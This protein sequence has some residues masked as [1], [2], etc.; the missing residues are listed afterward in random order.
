[1]AF[2]LRALIFDLDGVIAS[3]LPLHYDSWQRLSQE[4]AIPFTAEQY[5]LMQG[6]PRRKSMDIFLDGREVSEETAQAW[7]ARKNDFFHENLHRMTPAHSMPGAPELIREAH[8]S[9][10]K[11][12]LGSSSQ[13]ARRVLE[14]LELLP[15]FDVVADGN[16]VPNNKPAPD[17]YWW[18]AERL[19]V[20]PTEA[21]VFED[22]E[23]GLQAALA[24]GFWAV[25]VGDAYT[26]Q[27]HLAAPGLNDVTLAD[28]Y[29]L[30]D[31]PPR[32]V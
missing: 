3:T 26:S 17:I 16:T 28:L 24:G 14:K 23:S 12:G 20:K 6:L 13:N 7:M 11:I 30:L 19:G 32:P 25:A 29:R 15:Y 2:K 22:S 1:M 31:Q 21:V 8:A 27:P 9:G 18:V 4:V 10:L 5:R